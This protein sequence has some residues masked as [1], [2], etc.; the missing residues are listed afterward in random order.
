MGKQ[1]HKYNFFLEVAGQST[2][3]EGLDL[4]LCRAHPPSGKRNLSL[5]SYELRG[6]S[7]RYA[8]VARNGGTAREFRSGARAQRP[9]GAGLPDD[10]VTE[11][12]LK[13]KQ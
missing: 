4:A 1:L 2:R 11:A 6:S 5:T 8:L 7:K 9:G 10:K 3:W 13:P 12:E